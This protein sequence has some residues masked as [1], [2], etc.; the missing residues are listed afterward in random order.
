ME[1][2]HI[3]DAGAPA[4]LAVQLDDPAA[5][6]RRLRR[7]RGAG[8]SLVLVALLFLS[9]LPTE[10]L[11][12]LV[13]LIGYEMVFLSPLLQRLGAGSQRGTLTL[14]PGA[15]VVTTDRGRT[16]LRARDLLGGTAAREPGSERIVLTLSF[17]GLAAYP[18]SVTFAG[19]EAMEQVRR[20]L[21]V[22]RLGR[23]EVSIAGGRPGE[24]RRM[25]R[26]LMLALGA[27]A[28]FAVASSPLLLFFALGMVLAGEW[29][30]R[31]T[32]RLRADRLDFGN[33]AR[34]EIA[35]RDVTRI[36]ESD[37]Q[38]TIAGRHFGGR[39]EVPARPLLD[40]FTVRERA[41]FVAQLH[42]AV[43]RSRGAPPPPLSTEESLAQLRR[44]TTQGERAAGWL[45]RLDAFAA[46]TRASR[47]GAGYR[48]ASIDVDA[49]WTT[50]EDP[51]ADPELRCVAA[52][53]LHL[54]REST[55]PNDGAVRVRIATAVESAADETARTRLRIMTEDE[56]AELE[57][58]EVFPPDAAVR[59][60]P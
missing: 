51:D 7:L 27:W 43:E 30:T 15:V 21:G 55:E 22:G 36:R 10:W 50:L 54:R 2:V 5:R 37:G 34:T 39:L 6:Q 31:Q 47:E 35:Y 52:R 25:W 1:A 20:A 38:L 26:V 13:A 17:A 8:I 53:I 19:V 12:P 48:G 49:L 4:R 57:L 40:P 3:V 32:I 42:G 41:L 56:P 59:R 58:E 24:A 46:L 28:P 14:E 44:F 16:K 33:A 11:G 9:W 23:G 45:S 18:V 60:V 29:F